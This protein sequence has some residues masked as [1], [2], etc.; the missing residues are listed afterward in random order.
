MSGTSVRPFSVVATHWCSGLATL[1]VN[2]VFVTALSWTKTRSRNTL[3][4]R[5]GFGFRVPVLRM[6]SWS[7]GPAAVQASEEAH[8][9]TRTKVGQIGFA[10]LNWG[11]T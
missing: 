4:L 10:G 5:F 6:G 7:Q 8:H 1:A 9:K 3:Y 2:L 11:S